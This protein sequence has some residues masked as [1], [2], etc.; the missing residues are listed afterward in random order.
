V[1]FDP[2]VVP[3]EAGPIIW[4]MAMNM[5]THDAYDVRDAGLI[6]CAV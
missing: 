6:N 2:H 1:S 5:V 4:C 3:H